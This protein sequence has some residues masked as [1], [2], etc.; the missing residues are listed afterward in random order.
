MSKTLVKTIVALLLVIGIL[1]GVG[2]VSLAAPVELNVWSWRSEDVEAYQQMFAEFEKTNP[3]IKVKFSTYLDAEYEVILS[4]A[5]KAGKGPDIAQLK[6]YGELQPLINAGLLVSL[7]GKI[8]ELSNFT[9]VAL[10]GARSR[11]DGKIY[12]VP[13]S[14]P[15]MGIFY[16]RA[17]FA[18][19]G[20]TIPQ[21]WDEFIQMCNTLKSKGVT[22]IA[23]GGASGS[24]WAL[25]IMVGVIGP[26]FYGADTFWQDI[27]TGKATF[28]DPRFVKA[29]TKI[30][31]L[32]PYLTKGFE[33]IDY[34]AACSE[35]VNEDAAMFIGGSWENGN[36]K[37]QNPSLDF[38]IFPCPP[39]E[40]GQPAYTSAFCDGSYGITTNSKHQTEALKLMRFM[41]S[42]EFGQMYADLLG[43][44]PA[45][46]D[47]SANDR[48]LKSMLE[49]QEYQTP[50]LPLVGF[51]WETPTASQAIQSGISSMLAG[52]ITPEQ[53]AKNVNDAV[54]TWFKPSS[55]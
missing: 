29:L 27:T 7:E 6:A 10:D 37:Y 25:E 47:I 41:A 1:T 2:P 36:F 12:G 52:R 33:G 16:N 43:W 17:I 5:L 15:N 44:P 54:M 13:Y 38:D 42:K 32:G 26:N 18:K 50:Y 39:E 28:T 55:K 19:Y 20:L 24:A 34:V 30:Q 21:T 46:K 31:A 3:G 11:A 22:P 40:K 49:M 23:A 53:L 45:M 51:R 14:I 4:T 35:F 8:P 9:D 48:V